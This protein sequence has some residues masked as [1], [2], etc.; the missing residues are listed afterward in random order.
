MFCWIGFILIFNIPVF[1][2]GFLKISILFSTN[3]QCIVTNVNLNVSGTFVAERAG[4]YTRGK[5][6]HEVCSRIKVSRTSLLGTGFQGKLASML[7][8]TSCYLLTYLSHFCNQYEHCDRYGL[9][10]KH[11]GASKS[12]NKRR[13]CT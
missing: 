8:T 6:R 13:F 2:I 12:N 1:K 4:K 5:E 10:F 7:M 9:Y 3:Q 11:T